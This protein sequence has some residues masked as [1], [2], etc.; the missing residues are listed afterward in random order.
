M[1]PHYA[2]HLKNLWGE[3]RSPKTEE[4]V[5]NTYCFCYYPCGTIC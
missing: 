4:S 1:K 2:Q 5:D 3:N